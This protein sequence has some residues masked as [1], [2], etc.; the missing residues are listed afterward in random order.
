MFAQSVIYNDINAAV[1]RMKKMRILTLY[2]LLAFWNQIRPDKTS[3]PDLYP[4]C[5]TLLKDIFEKLILTNKISIKACKISQRELYL[6]HTYQLNH[7]IS[8]DV[9]GLH[10][11]RCYKIV[12]PCLSACT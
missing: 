2:L 6:Y 11:C 4:N 10:S 7:E 8:H 5:L 12:I 1:F 9:Q 3:R